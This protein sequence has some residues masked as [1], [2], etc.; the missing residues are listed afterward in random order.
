MKEGFG[1]V[2]RHEWRGG[3]RGREWDKQKSI[4][5]GQETGKSSFGMSQ[6]EEKEVLP[7]FAQ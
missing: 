6:L 4:R 3:R 7:V 2:C 5:V 1:G